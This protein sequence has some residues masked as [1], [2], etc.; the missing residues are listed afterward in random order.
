MPET[1]GALGWRFCVGLVHDEASSLDLPCLVEAEDADVGSR[2]GRLALLN[3]V[4]HLVGVLA[5]EQRQLPH[6]PV[7]AVIVS[8]AGVVLPAD[9]TVLQ[10]K[11]QN[12]CTKRGWTMKS[13]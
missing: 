1:V 10:Q 4:Q 12:E 3:L 6:C 5:A 11:S 13:I 2:E 8:R 9:E 7:A